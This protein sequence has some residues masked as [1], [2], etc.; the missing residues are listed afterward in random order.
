MKKKLLHDEKNLIAFQQGYK[1]GAQNELSLDYLC[2]S[3]VYGF[4]RGET[5]VGGYVVC[6]GS[7]L[8]IYE[9]LAATGCDVDDVL[10]HSRDEFVEVTSLWFRRGCTN[11]ERSFAYINML[12]DAFSRGRRYLLGASK[13]TKTTAIFMSC[14]PNP[15]CDV[16]VEA[17]GV[18]AAYWT[19][20]D[21][22]FHVTQG[23]RHWALQ[24]DDGDHWDIELY[25]ENIG[26]EW[27]ANTLP[28]CA[29]LVPSE[30]Y[31]SYG[32]T[33]E[34]CEPGETCCD[35]LIKELAGCVDTLTD[36]MHC[37]RCNRACVPC[38]EG[39]CL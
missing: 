5:L 38:V 6:D 39:N 7:E 32:A 16:E 28:D 34:V 11:L 3:R 8:R 33:P 4:Y 26:N 13:L 19:L 12:V 10:P 1:L 2:D 22:V 29:E 36:P 21:S 35:N 27:R 23:V 9:I 18:D 14:L 15:G 30:R 25:Y 24:T 20:T 31:C 37:G 17:H